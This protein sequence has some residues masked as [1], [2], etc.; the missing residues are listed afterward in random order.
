MTDLHDVRFPGE[1]DGYRQARDALLREELNLRDQAERLA[2]LRRDLPLGGQAREDYVFAD[3]G[4]TQGAPVHLSELFAEGKDTLLLYGLMYGTDADAPCPMCSAF[5]DSL[6]GNAPHITQRA[7]LA[8]VARA[9]V[10]KLRQLAADRGWRQLRL[11]SSRDNDYGRDYHTEGPDGDQ[12]PILHVFKKTADG[13]F[14]TYASEVF[15]AGG[16]DRPFDPRH[17]DPM[18]GLWHLLDVTPAGRGNWYPSLSY[19]QDR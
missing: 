19:D 5:L 15:Y 9:P 3:A 2:Q 12:W 11:L 18:W 7:N 6:D 13:V 17:M 4:M 8:V 16:D 10:E 1:S 14:H